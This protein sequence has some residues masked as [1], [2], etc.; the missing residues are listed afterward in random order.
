MIVPVYYHNYMMGE[1]FAAQVHEKLAR[2][3]DKSITEAVY[4]GRPQVGEFLKR[5]VFAPGAR[6]RWDEL[7]R[8]VTGDDLGA[9][10]FARRFEK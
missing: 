1:L 6:L 9:E 5:E 2:I 8:E 4:A 7:T 10:A 3:E